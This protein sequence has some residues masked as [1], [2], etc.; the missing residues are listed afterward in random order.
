MSN[1]TRPASTES[2]PHAPGP[3]E[4]AAAIPEP[5]AVDQ[6]ILDATVR[7]P[8]AER[9]DP[10]RWSL[11]AKIGLA[12]VLAALV[13]MAVL[14]LFSLD[15]GR[16]AVETAQLDS[17]EGSA[18]EAAVAVR[19][20]LDGVAVRADQLGTRADV[21]AYLTGDRTGPAPDL[22]ENESNDV[23]SALLAAPDGVVVDVETD[24]LTDRAPR[25]VVSQGWFT[26]AVSGLITIAPVVVN[27][28]SGV[29]SVTVAAPARNPGSGVVGVAAIDVRGLDVLN[30][31]NQAQLASGGQSLL[32]DADGVVVVARDSRVVG[33]TLDEL[34]L[35]PLAE[36][37]NNATLGTLT[38]VTLDG[39]G[40]QV[41]AFNEVYEGVTA[42]V[43]QPESVFLGPINRLGTITWFLFGVVGLLAV[44]GAVLL[45]RRL[46][47]PVGVLTAAA[48][49]IEANQPVDED[50]LARIGRSGDDVGRLARVFAKM[51]EQVVVRERKLR[52]QVKALKVEIDHERR[53]RA[54]DEVTDTDFFRDLQGRAAEMRRRAKGEPV[55]STQS[56]GPGD[57][58]ADGGDAVGGDAVGGDAAATD[59]AGD[60]QG[61]T[62]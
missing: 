61:A 46:S 15:A 62:S 52:E 24:T 12:L 9:L 17:V 16:E 3:S 42:V 19:Q 11:G 47:R 36:A 1:P 2:V 22:G 55:V 37:I 44:T 7:P 53:Q 8:L 30:S 31:L 4:P 26:D 56:A 6:V 41:A 43:L 25:S 20:Y 51:A 40:E 33:R 45:G 49:Q 23:N 18:T 50:E 28:A 35:G 14:A 58:D 29:S 59:V 5:E 13:P 54:V 34:G 48:V 10:R 32:V 57:G 60:E 21:V 39:R 38:G 27:P